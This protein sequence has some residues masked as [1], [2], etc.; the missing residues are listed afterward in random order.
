MQLKNQCLKNANEISNN[1][2]FRKG[3]RRPKQEILIPKGKSHHA[4]N[5]TKDI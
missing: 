1:K 4:K 2:F 3:R 5:N